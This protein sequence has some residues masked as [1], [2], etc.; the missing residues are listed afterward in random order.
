VE[1]PAPD[2]GGK[3]VRETQN[4]VQF[5]LSA[6]CANVER[7]FLN[8]NTCILSNE[9]TACASGTYDINGGLNRPKFFVELNDENIRGIYNATGNG[10]DGTRYL[11]AIDGLQVA[12]DTTIAK[13]C[14]RAWS[15]WIPIN[16]TGAEQ[17]QNATIQEIFSQLLYHAADK[18]N[19]Y[20]RD[21]YNSYGTPCP[22]LYSKSTG[23]EVLD[24]NK[25]HCWKHVHPDHLSVYDMTFW[26]RLGTHP[27]NSVYRNPIKEFAESGKTTL[28]FPSSH[29]MNYWSD[30]KLVMG[31]YVGRYGDQVH[32]YDFPNALRSQMLNEYFGFSPY[33]IN[34]T[35]SKGIVVCGSPNEIENDLTLG[36][37]QGRGAFDIY[38]QNFVA[39]E[40]LDTLKQ[41]RIVWT[42]VI[43]TAKDQLRQRVAWALSQILAVS[44]AAIID[45]EFN[46]EGMTAF[47]DIFVRNAFGNYR[48][49]LKEISYNSLM[50]EMLTYYRSISTAFTW[51]QSRRIQYADENFAREIMQL[52]TIGNY[53][54]KPDGS[55][56]LNN[57]GLP[58]RAYT[59]DE[60][61]EYARA[62]TGF[63]SRNHRGNVENYYWNHIDP[64]KIMIEYRDILPK[65]GLDRKYVGDGFPLCSD[66]PSKLFLK[67]G[68]TYRLLGSSSLPELMSDPPKWASDPLTKRL[69]LQPNGPD[70]LFTK[71][72]GSEDPALCNFKSKIVLDRN[73]ACSG[74]ECFVET[75]RVVEVI[76]GIYYEY[77]SL[78]CVYQAYYQNAKTIWKRTNWVE[79]VCADPRT[80]QASV[81]CCNATN[82]FWDEVVSLFMLMYMSLHL[83]NLIV[84]LVCSIGEKELRLQL[85]NNAAISNSVHA[86]KGHRAIQR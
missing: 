21:I 72:C 9:P 32:Y 40:A 70:S 30:N 80:V 34:Y 36:G 33:S 10:T 35:D 59:N 45:G 69:R 13:P 31:L 39:T 20:I 7:T 48:D 16:C 76:P 68:A 22:S 65:M 15:R 75:L 85:L 50:A 64:M 60:I 66:Q 4:I 83:I 51:K 49:I 57:Q 11:Y 62:W 81:A 53:K 26:T 43:L 25:A 6:A 14:D 42:H 79:I 41:K 2:G 86:Y 55:F 24:F 3:L 23:F 1:N 8:E 37:S 47:Y 58:V 71:L 44:P 18:S 38:N 52:F 56:I 46:T 5:D 74:E 61:V 77:T 54:L 82:T 28:L 67:S 27:G 84:L 17:K 19:P 78:P 63:Y 29:T 12:N 73:L